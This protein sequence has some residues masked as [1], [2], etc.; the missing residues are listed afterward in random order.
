MVMRYIF[1]LLL[2]GC[3]TAVPPGQGAPSPVTRVV[4]PTPAALPAGMVHFPG[5]SESLKVQNTVA[6]N[7]DSL[8]RGYNLFQHQCAPCHA[9][10]LSG[11]ISPDQPALHDLRLSTSYKYGTTDQALYRTIRFGIPGTAMGRHN[12]P[13]PQIFDLVNFLRSRHKP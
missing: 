4:S 10:D 6:G 1:A 7:G 13:N 2:V 3:S 11:E 12:L 9:R 5:Y 8:A